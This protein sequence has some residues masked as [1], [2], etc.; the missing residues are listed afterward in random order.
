MSTMLDKRVLFLHDRSHG[1]LTQMLG[2]GSALVARVVG[3]QLRNIPPSQAQY[4]ETS[5]R[6]TF[7]VDH[8]S[9]SKAQV[10]TADKVDAVIVDIRSQAVQQ[11]GQIAK[12]FSH[13]PVVL[14]DSRARADRLPDDSILDNFDL[15]FKREPWKDLDRYPCSPANR[16][17]IVPTMIS[18]RMFPHTAAGVRFP[19]WFRQL[20]GQKESGSFPYQYDVS[21]IGK[22]TNQDR[23]ETCLRI[24]RESD[25]VSNVG[26]YFFDRYDKTV[27][28][29]ESE[30]ARLA[31]TQLNTVPYA[32]LIAASKVNLAL[33]G[34]GQFTYR[35]LEIW[36]LASFLLTTPVID[37]I[38]LPGVEQRSGVHYQTYNS[39]DDMIDKIRYYATHDAEREKIA[40]AAGA[41]FSELYDPQKHGEFIRERM[42][43]A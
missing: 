1:T 42:F 16:D 3:P 25:L 43:G 19:R 11:P 26:L 24:Q 4:F 15:V 32:R 6:T 14:F 35:H 10:V 41:L 20:K 17:K 30:R 27:T 33:E 28:A 23:V 9:T 8:A 39:V 18:C 13:V 31:T 38:Q 5:I 2:W 12:R 40:A 21:F 22:N 37:E 34:L 29:T 7:T 36:S